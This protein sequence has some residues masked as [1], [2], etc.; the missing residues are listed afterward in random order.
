MI[1][2][3]PMTNR[4]NES[5]TSLAETSPL[6]LLYVDESACQALAPTLVAWMI[7]WCISSSRLPMTMRTDYPAWIYKCRKE[8]GTWLKW[9]AKKEPR[10]TPESL[11]DSATPEYLDAMMVGSKSIH[12]ITRALPVQ[13]VRK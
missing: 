5:L 12:L 2:Y 4:Q 1:G 3:A 11:I 10:F 13:S 9:R 6:T 7:L 8:F